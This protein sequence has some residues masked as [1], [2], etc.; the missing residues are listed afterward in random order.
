M[1]YC[2]QMQN[3]AHGLCSHEVPLCPTIHRNK[4]GCWQD[5]TGIAA[6]ECSASPWPSVH[7]NNSCCLISSSKLISPNSSA[8]LLVKYRHT[9]PPSFCLSRGRAQLLTDG[10]Q[11]T[12]EDKA[13]VWKGGLVFTPSPS[14]SIA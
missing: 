6:P 2:M 10:A 12:T 4:D 5:F 7:M 3:R 9:A 1:T 11:I 13:I 14:A 8:L